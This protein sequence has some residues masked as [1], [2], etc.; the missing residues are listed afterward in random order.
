MNEKIKMRLD[1]FRSLPTEK[2]DKPALRRE[3]A[4]IGGAAA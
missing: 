4:S 1:I 3:L 2:L